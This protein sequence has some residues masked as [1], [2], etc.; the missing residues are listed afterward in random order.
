MATEFGV[1]PLWN[2]ILCDGTFEYNMQYMCE[3]PFTIKEVNFV[4]ELGYAW[5]TSVEGTENNTKLSCG[6]WAITFDML[7]PYENE[8]ENFE[9]A[10]YDDLVSLW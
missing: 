4:P 7:E 3:K 1:D 2:A 9:C 8:S 10:T 5:V 6:R